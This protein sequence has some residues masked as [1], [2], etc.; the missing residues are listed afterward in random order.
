MTDAVVSNDRWQ[1]TWRGTAPV[2]NRFNAYN[3]ATD[4]PRGRH[5]QF[6]AGQDAQAV[7]VTVQGSTQAPTPVIQSSDIFMGSDTYGWPPVEDAWA[8]PQRASS[9]NLIPY[10][11]ITPALDVRRVYKNAYVWSE[12]EPFVRQAPFSSIII[13]GVSQLIQ[14]PS[15]IGVQQNIA[16]ALLNSLTFNVSITLQSSFQFNAGIVS[17]QSPLGGNF[18]FAGSTVNLVVSIGPGPGPYPPPPYVPPPPA[19][20]GFGGDQWGANGGGIIQNPTPP[21]ILQLLSD[22]V[23]PANGAVGTAGKNTWTQLISIGIQQAN[24]PPNPNAVV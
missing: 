21:P 12:Y 24:Q 16:I 15:L 9:V 18:A 22:T 23:V 8:P 2:L 14:V 13:V 19:P 4:A 7:T 1:S 20:A 3:P 11:P 17:G 6:F 10:A 5:A